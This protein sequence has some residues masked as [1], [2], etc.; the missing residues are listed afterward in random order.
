[1][2]L[3][4]QRKGVRPIQKVLQR[5]SMDDELRNRLWSALKLTVLDKWEGPTAY[6][7]QDPNSREVHNLFRFIW[8]NHFK[9]PIDT[10]PYDH[11][12]RYSAL[13]DYFFR[14]QWWEV[15][16]LLEFII[17]HVPKEWK[18]SLVR[19]VNSFLQEENADCRVVGE[20]IVPITDVNELQAI[21]SALDS[22]LRSV[23]QHLARA[24]ELLSDRKNPDYRNS[25][26]ESISAVEAICQIIS[27]KEK[28][29]LPDCLK[30]L[31]QQKPLHPAFEQALVKLYSYTSDEGGI[32]HALSDDSSA[33][34]FADAKFMLVSSSG[35]VNYALT[36]AAEVGIKIKKR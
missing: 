3:F 12:D 8:L 2:A 16:D 28:A 15:Y 30:A 4:S 14:C 17:K 20:E 5:D 33:P 9:K 7:Y 34:S 26:K 27:G 35:F 22:G 6:A 25:M 19:F 21:E 13:R 31:K 24:A 23:T 10:L 1:M 36:K 11:E 32:R 18:D 29:T